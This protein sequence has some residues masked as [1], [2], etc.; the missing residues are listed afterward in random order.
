MAVNDPNL[1]AKNTP[2]DP[3]ES[4]REQTER[5]LREG[6]DARLDQQEK[7][8]P[9]LAGI[10]SID[11]SK[12]ISEQVEGLANL[13][14]VLDELILL[15]LKAG[16]T[17]EVLAK[18]P[19]TLQGYAKNDIASVAIK[20]FGELLT[21]QPAAALAWWAKNLEE[22]SQH[23]ADSVEEKEKTEKGEKS[24]KT[25]WM[26]PTL[27]WGLV[28][29]GAAGAAYFLY[30][31]FKEEGEK[32]E[33]S[34]LV[35]GGALATIGIGTL[36]GANTLG[37]WAADYLNLDVSADAVKDLLS[38]KGLNSILFS[39]R[40]PG[41][42]KAAKK[43][44][45]TERTLIDLK[46]V[47]WSDFSGL[48]PDL[49]RSGKSYIGAILEQAGMSEVPGMTMDD[50]AE[51]AREEV[52]LESFIKRHQDK[53][54][55][56]INKMS[57]GEILNQL[58]A[59]GVFGTPEHPDKKKDEEASAEGTPEISD[60]LSSM[61]TVAGVIQSI[62]TGEMDWDEGLAAL[63]PAADEDGAGLGIIDGVLFLG[64]GALIVPL[65][66]LEVVVEQAKDMYDFTTGEGT[67]GEAVWAD[68]Q[69]Y[70]AVGYAGFYGGAAVIK[71][72]RTGN[73]GVGPVLGEAMKGGFKG[74]IDSY[75]FIPNTIIRGLKWK[76]EGGQLMNF[77]RLTSKEH[78][79]FL[80]P[81]EKIHV[82]HEQASYYGE[83]YNYYHKKLEAF[84]SSEVAGWTKSKIYEKMYGKAWLEKMMERYAEKF[85]K[86]RKVF[87]EGMGAAD[88]LGAD[89]TLSSVKAD[90]GMQG[91]LAEAAKNFVT[92]NPRT[93]LPELPAYRVTNPK[94]A[95]HAEATRA[96]VHLERNIPRD[97]ISRMEALGLKGDRI[98]LKLRE[99]G[100]T[101]ADLQTL[102][103][104]LERMPNP[105]QAAKDLEMVLWKI[106]H[107][108]L[109]RVGGTLGKAAGIIGAIY[110]LYDFQE[111]KDKWNTLGEDVSMLG[112]FALGA[113]VTA[114]AI[115]HPIGKV[116]GGIAG[117]TLA[118]FGGMAAWNSYGKP[119]LQKHFPNR[120][121][122]YKNSFVSGTGTVLS[123]MTG[124]V[125]I[126]DI[127]FAADAMGI[128]DGV[129]EETDPIAYLTDSK[130]IGH[131]DFIDDVFAGEK[132]MAMGEHRMHDL[133]E[134][135]SNGQEA[136][137]G[138]Q[139]EIKDLQEE[140][141]EL[142]SEEL[143][144][145]DLERKEDITIRKDEILKEIEVLERASIRFQSYTD[146]SWV[147][148]KQMELIYIQTEMINPAFEKF[149]TVV[150]K[151]FGAE[152]LE[153][154]A[155]LMG[156]MQE[157]REGVKGDYEMQV[158]QYLCDQS[159]ELGEGESLP[160]ADFA[161]FTVS[162]Y[163]SAKRLEEIK[164]ELGGGKESSTGEEEVTPPVEQDL[165]A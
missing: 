23:Y 21:A 45:I 155:R 50:D 97:L 133:S 9:I 2:V 115:P 114:A 106:K 119:Y 67:L 122:F 164:K 101:K 137:E 136:L 29:A 33:T 110:M 76:T 85:L 86:S 63:Q 20:K 141:T 125:L 105:Q 48:R 151:K 75:L 3:L 36:L 16:E 73:L 139:S 54:K 25:E 99:Y 19:L 74:I 127:I 47:K 111:S 57:I 12:A 43:L 83:R 113:R 8:D 5:E 89:V 62:V 140:F 148:V 121:D 60:D 71:G 52:K 94:Y 91:R 49:V 98:T 51:I 102:C 108:R 88:T 116:V 38:G 154:F 157:G 160:F 150:A 53:I 123:M 30:K 69:I 65:S 90:K 18:S 46:D 31:W 159:V 7:K 40:E 22:G 145:D 32:K 72:V 27:K 87:L 10:E 55:G 95:T 158:W 128:G 24:D 165:A 15:A 93:G 129:D 118:S 112:T 162:I 34:N 80:S 117:G 163:Q 44:D 100:M 70:W 11:T 84:E 126:N 142:E 28:A 41:I 131:Y 130:Y 58:E 64:K 42:K 17:R 78:L 79:P 96:G 152:G 143:T 104:E 144:A 59:A 37:K 109:F 138:A 39:S 103:T 132:I 92:E 81:A 35:I 77:A 153:A 6:V 82:L 68:N 107:P 134:L 14:V 1:E 13:E 4:A 26:S 149:Q 135:R 147:V 61:P 66:S 56:D 120:Q 146:D 156:R 161:T 124:G